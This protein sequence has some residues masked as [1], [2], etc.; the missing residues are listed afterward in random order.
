MGIGVDTIRELEV[1]ESHG[2][3]QSLKRGYLLSG[4][5]ETT[6]PG[7]MWQ[8]LNY[9]GLPVDGS[10]ASGDSNL[11]CVGRQARPLPNCNTKAE[12]VVSYEPMGSAN[13]FIFSG[14]GS[15]NSTRTQVD[16]YGNELVV[17]HQWPSDD[18]DWPDKVDIQPIDLNVMQPQKTLVATGPLYVSYPD[19]VVDLWL[20]SMNSTGWAGRGPYEWMCVNCEFS[21]MRVGYGQA[22][23]WMFTFQF[24]HDFTTWIPQVFFTDPRTNKPA[25]NLTPG[26]GTRYVDWYGILDFNIL[27]PVR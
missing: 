10:L 7:L 19:Q 23:K 20:G 12:V 11:V 17:A 26:V 1:V 25:Y 8:A 21:P 27:F 14:G 22:R 13:R 4:L 18:E 3:V 16:R 5:D 15:L 2:V 24:Q 6:G 9:S